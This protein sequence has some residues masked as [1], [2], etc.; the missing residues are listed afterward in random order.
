MASEQVAIEVI[1][2]TKQAKENLKELAKSLEAS[3][4]HVFGLEKELNG[5]EKQLS[6]TSK[7]Q[8]AAQ[9]DL[10]DKIDKT[11]N[12]IK[13]EKFAIKDIQQEQTK[14]NK[15]IKEGT[16]NQKDYTGVLGMLDNLT[17]G[18]I[19]KIKGMGS[20]LGG[21]TKGM[22]ALKVAIIGTGIGALVIAVTSLIAAF[23]SSEEG[24]NKFSKIMGVIGTVIGNVVD[25]IADFGEGIIS[26]FENPKKAISDFVNLI[27]ENIQNRFE[28]ILDTIGYLGKAIKSVFTGEFSEALDYAKKAGSSYV[29]S[30]TGVKNTLDKVAG[31]VGD[32]VEEQ[33][34]EIEIA[35]QIADARAKA[36]KQ[37]RE[38][39]VERAEADRKVAD[40]REKSADKER[41]SA[42]ERIKMIQEAGRIAEE[43][44]NKE[45][46]NAKLLYDAKVKENALSKST[47]EDLDEEAQLKAQV[48]QLE[49]AR[50]RK[51]KALTAELT[52]TR[53][54]ANAELEAE[55]KALADLNKEITEATATELDQQ[56]QLE[57]DKIKAHYDDLINR[58][59]EQGLSIIELDKAKNTVLKRQM[60]EFIND[61]KNAREKRAADEKALKDKQADEDKARHE[62]EL[63][64]EQEKVAQKHWALDQIMGLTNQESALGKA[65]FV[66]KQILNAKELI[67][68]AQKTVTLMTNDAAKAQV[69]AATG[70][71]ETAK[72]GFPQNIPL[73][74]GYAAQA[75]G[76]IGSVKKALSAA[77]Q[78]VRGA[79]SGGLNIEAPTINA[80]QSAAP[81][82]NIVGASQSNQLAEVVAGQQQQPIKAY[83][84]SSDVSTAQSL[85]RNII[86]GAGI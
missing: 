78:G 48:I 18:A 4:D 62:E 49:T 58:A 43:I 47:K 68:N 80:G 39:L 44:T 35:K 63:K 37:E 42:D 10:K 32:F 56:R 86:Q 24:Q 25:I 83:V 7:T 2:S 65:A 38:L 82:F 11:K 71:A 52:T 51:Q 27:K 31:A 79:S 41:F 30:L 66:A 1:A 36:T 84:V 26:A 9:K 81:S 14:Y 57:L 15:V 12:A 67:A 77:K 85:D 8:L 16:E 53:K 19:S 61:D 55:K 73:L 46:E 59:R 3:K 17:G 60:E 64:A 72:V 76:I 69:A 40:L 21:A 29:D 23:K 70:V 33:K 5:L 22:K 54:E 34:R 45:I 74:I 50:L 28:A 20:A 75:V 6:K 13:E